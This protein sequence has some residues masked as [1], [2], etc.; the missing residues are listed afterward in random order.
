MNEM[1]KQIELANKGLVATA[2]VEATTG[3]KRVRGK[4]ITRGTFTVKEKK[5][6][7]RTAWRLVED[8][9]KPKVEVEWPS[10]LKV[11]RSGFWT[12]LVTKIRH[13]FA[14][15]ILEEVNL[16]WVGV[17]VVC[18][19]MN[20]L[21]GVGVQ[22]AVDE[23]LGVFPESDVD[24]GKIEE[25]KERVHWCIRIYR[26]GR[27]GSVGEFK[28]YSPELKRTPY[29]GEISKIYREMAKN[30]IIPTY[31]HETGGQCRVGQPIEYSEEADTMEEQ[32]AHE[33]ESYNRAT[34]DL[35]TVM[36]QKYTEKYM[37]LYTKKYGKKYAMAHAV[38][39]AAKVARRK[40][41]D[42]KRKPRDGA[43]NL[44][45]YGVKINKDITDGDVRLNLQCRYPTDKAKASKKKGNGG[46]SYRLGS[47]SKVTKIVDKR[48]AMGNQ[49]AVKEGTR[50]M[51]MAI[52]GG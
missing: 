2:T 21:A 46:G 39:H 17:V 35:E 51:L 49:D 8:K 43:R 6:N 33:E 14:L 52:M 28:V 4:V 24:M 37:A 3:S 45:G 9:S 18:M 29:V 48:D 30:G 40:I 23:T 20:G 50:A 15:P 1:M 34:C 16:R 47:G 44:Y 13:P 25:G 10:Y 36:I 27:K 31:V 22:S 19:C 42:A 32:I 7:A 12:N 38:D 41:D 5:V 26:T 11:R